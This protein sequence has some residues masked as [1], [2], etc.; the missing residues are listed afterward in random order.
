MNTVL[1]LVKNEVTTEEKDSVILQ[2]RRYTITCPHCKKSAPLCEWGFVQTNWYESPYGCSGGACWN[3]YDDI[4]QCLLVCP[5]TCGENQQNCATR[6]YDLPIERQEKD[7]VFGLLKKQTGMWEGNLKRI[8]AEHYV[9]YGTGKEIE[10]SEDVRR[11]RENDL[12]CC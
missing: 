8:F 5:F 12:G 7:W 3:T 9:Q 1:T 11:Q 4:L 6:I 2:L 10:T